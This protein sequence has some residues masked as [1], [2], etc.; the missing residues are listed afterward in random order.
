MQWHRLRNTAP[1]PDKHA[2]RVSCGYL[3]ASLGKQALHGVTN[4]HANGTAN[5]MH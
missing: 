5:G 1:T 4:G 2:C 3:Q